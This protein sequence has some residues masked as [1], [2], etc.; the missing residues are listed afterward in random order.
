M[1]DYRSCTRVLFRKY[2]EG[3][4]VAVFPD[5]PGTSDPASCMTYQSIGQH[6]SAGAALVMAHTSPARPGEYAELKRE[7]VSI[8]YADLHT[9]KRMPPTAYRN[10][11]ALVAGRAMLAGR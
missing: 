11:Q 9:V 2:G 1:K 8:G 3:D 4:I 10:R 7:L 5:E 6:C